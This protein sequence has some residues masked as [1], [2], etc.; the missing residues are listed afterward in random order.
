MN[1]LT[2]EQIEK[3]LT[4]LDTAIKRAINEQN[5]LIGYK[6]CLIEQGEKDEQIPKGNKEP[7]PKVRSKAN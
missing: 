5:Q 3:R 4:E 6:Q 1:T 7:G 2:I